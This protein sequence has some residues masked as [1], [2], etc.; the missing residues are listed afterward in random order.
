[1]Q[2][3]APQFNLQSKLGV[4]VPASSVLGPIAPYYIDQFGLSSDCKVIAFTGDNPCECGLRNYP[5][6]SCDQHTVDHM[7][8]SFAGGHATV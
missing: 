5:P 4:P 1:M 2:A 8:C 3:C 6:E 7:T